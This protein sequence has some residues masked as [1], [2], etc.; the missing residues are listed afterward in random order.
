MVI[1]LGLLVEF[2]VLGANRY[3][4]EA[5]VTLQRAV[6]ADDSGSDGGLTPEFVE[7]QY[8]TMRSP[9]VA[10]TA[11]A[12]LGEGGIEMTSEEV[13]D[14]IEF[15]R[16]PESAMMTIV[17]HH[18][19]PDVS[20]ALANAVAD[21]YLQVYREQVEAGA[22]FQM[23][24]IDAQISGIDVR[25]DEIRAER[26][27][28]LD[29]DPELSQIQA[30]AEEAV[31]LIADLQDALAGASGDEADAMRQEIEDLR[32]RITIFEEVV[33]SPVG[34]ELRAL[35]EEETQEQSRRAELVASRDEFSVETDLPVEDLALVQP[36]LAAQRQTGAGTGR[37]LGVSALA[38]LL[39]GLVLAYSL[40]RWRR[41]LTDRHEPQ[42]VL[43]TP[44]LADIPDFGQESLD[45]TVPVRD[46]AR[47]AAAEA[48]R[49]AASSLESLARSRDVKSVFV[50]S[51]TLGHGKTTTVVNIGVAGALHGSSVLVVDCDFG[52][53]VASRLLLGNRSAE[54]A[55]VT[56]VVEGV[57]T[58]DQAAHKVELGN[59]VALSLMPRGT[60]P[61]LAATALASTAARDLFTGLRDKYDFTL[62]DGPPLLQVAYASTLAELA[63]GL[64]VVVEH[65][66]SH[67][68]LADLTSRLAILAPPV[69]GYVYNRSPLRREMTTS[70]GSMKDVLGEPDV[71][72]PPSRRASARRR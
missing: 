31:Q 70:S 33:S 72:V 11:A 28:L 52:N 5:T 13:S 25:L 22:L 35:A 36:A 71:M 62:I 9:L 2:L 21:A 57:A 19:A 26:Q 48:C 18:P 67:A 10:G 38:G 7:I 41:T 8:E 54:A 50:V 68:E 30:Q 29:A 69:L 1:A 42:D 46:Y 55:G 47:S 59:G 49:F 51:A 16:E 23:S 45:S 37:M 4:A 6:T 20:V 14:S 63:D 61:G 34:P 15:E 27:E 60:R 43:G 40:T 65:E 24:R 17:A 12:V 3:S 66:S 53:Q 56:D 58:P 32:S 39:L 64:L 44:L